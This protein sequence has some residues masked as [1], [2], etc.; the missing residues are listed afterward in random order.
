MQ[1]VSEVLDLLSEKKLKPV[2][3]EPIYEGLE[4]VSKGL[5]DLEGRKIWGKGVVRIRGDQ[6]EGGKAKL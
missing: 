3:Y 4:G 6:A 5:A 2:I 1:V